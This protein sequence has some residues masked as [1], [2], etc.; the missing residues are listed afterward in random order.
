VLTAA[1]IVAAIGGGLVSGLLM[2][3]GFAETTPQRYR[4]R[5]GRP[6][7]VAAVATTVCFAVATV[8]FGY[9]LVVGA[10]LQRDGPVILLWPWCSAGLAVSLPAA[11]RLTLRDRRQRGPR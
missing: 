4:R 1:V 3:I 11:W 5:W 8:I 9:T 10:D 2:R 7:L 6:P